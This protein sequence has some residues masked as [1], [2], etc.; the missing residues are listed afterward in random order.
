MSKMADSEGSCE[1][2]SNISTVNTVNVNTTVCLE[3]INYEEKLKQVNNEL[4]SAEMIIQILQTELQSPRTMDTSCKIN[5]IDTGEQDK[6][7]TAD[8]WNGVY[9]KTNS[10]K[11]KTKDRSNAINNTGLNY[12]IITSNRFTMLH[13]LKEYEGERDEQ[14][15]QD[16]QVRTYVT[17]KATGRRTSGQIIPTIVNGIAQYTGNRKLFTNKNK[18][19][20]HEILILGDSHARGCAAEVKHYLSNEFEVHG[21]T[22]SGAEMEVI[23]ASADKKVHQLTNKDVMVLWGGS[24]DVARNNSTEGLKMI[25]KLITETKHTNV[26]LLTVPH[27]H[28][29]VPNSCVNIEVE[30]FNRRLYKD[31]ERFKEV[32]IMEVVNERSYYTRHGQ[33]L[34]L[35]GKDY[36]AK[37]ITTMI[38]HILNNAKDPTRDERYRNIDPNSPNRQAPLMVP[39][40]DP[41]VTVTRN[42]EDSDAT[43]ILNS[44]T[45]QDTK[46]V[47]Q[48]LSN[49]VKKPTSGDAGLNLTIAQ[50]PFNNDEEPPNEEDEE[51]GP[52]IN[53][54][55]AEAGVACNN[56]G[57]TEVG[58][59]SIYQDTLSDESNKKSEQ[60]EAQ[61]NN[62]TNEAKNTQ[63]SSVLLRRNCLARR[64][65][66]FLWM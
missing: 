5:Q 25:S 45:T 66:D 4:K 3:C 1:K 15:T 31:A 52:S 51:G 37:R 47:P 65:P 2:Y 43:T 17:H 24:N 14:Q 59:T 35:A 40:S 21:T 56:Q 44:P 39:S 28:D 54:G 57:D 55:D 18:I 60:V 12:P 42:K 16:E 61:N 13:N 32:Q 62:N 6:N 33:H 36:M 30:V 7:Q 38:E 23:K 49:K 8:K 58:V 11:Q 41:K 19:R 9:V 26:I 22:I 34:N 46:Q 10:K 64:D 27:R 63:S 29:L 20:K 48:P 50:T 53:Q